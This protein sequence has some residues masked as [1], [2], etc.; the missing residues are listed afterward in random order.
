MAATAAI[1]QAEAQVG[2]QAGA[3]LRT[4]PAATAPPDPLAL[5]A[6]PALVTLDPPEAEMRGE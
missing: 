6:T 2:A 1:H 3:R 4:H 5:A